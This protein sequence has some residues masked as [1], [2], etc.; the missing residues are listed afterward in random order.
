M[1]N[2]AVNYNVDYV[3]VD[4]AGFVVELLYGGLVQGRVGRGERARHRKSEVGYD[5]L[6]AFNLHGPARSANLDRALKV[7]LRLADLRVIG[8]FQ[9]LLDLRLRAGGIETELEEAN[10]LVTV[11]GLNV[12]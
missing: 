6:H 4:G 1:Q 3:I 11:D 10:P 2:D 7:N 8:R 12:P 9:A 5:N